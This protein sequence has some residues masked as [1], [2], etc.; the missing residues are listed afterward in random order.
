M[1]QRRIGTIT[2]PDRYYENEEEICEVFRRIAFAPF[3]CE[4]IYASRSFEM[5]GLSPLFRQVPK[6]VMS[7]EYIINIVRNELNEISEVNLVVV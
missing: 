3:R 4:Y 2:I 5:T 7:K 6:G 1:E